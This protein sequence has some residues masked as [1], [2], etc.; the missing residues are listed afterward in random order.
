GETGKFD[1]PYFVMRAMERL[2]SPGV[3]VRL[4]RGG[5]VNVVPVD[6]VVDALAALSSTEASRGQTDHLTGPDPRPSAQLAEIL[7]RALG[8]QFVYGRMPLA[9]AKAA[10]SPRPVQRFFGM[11]VEAL[12]YFDDPVRHDATEATRDL[13]GLGIRCPRLEDY[14]PKLVSFYRAH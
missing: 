5:T 3:F 11:P 9:V 10:F 14:V 2:P 8:K 1:G 6:F 4:G 12:D 7:A 13:A